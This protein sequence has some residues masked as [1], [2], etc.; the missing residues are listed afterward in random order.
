MVLP[1]RRNRWNAWRSSSAAAGFMPPSGSRTKRPRTRLS[2][3]AACRV[4]TTL[5]TDTGRRPREKNEDGDWS[6]SSPRRSRL[7]TVLA[8]TVLA[9]AEAAAIAISTIGMPIMNRSRP[10]KTPATVV[11]NWRMRGAIAFRQ[12]AGPP[13][14]AS[15]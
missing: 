14:H 1:A 10:T 2:V 9:P 3:S 4:C 15:P 11:K 8:G 12:G 5:I 7:R 13:G 6:V